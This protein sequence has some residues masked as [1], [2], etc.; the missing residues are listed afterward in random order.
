MV[1]INISNK[2]FYSLI[3]V[4]AITIVGVAVYAYGTS[5]PS[6]FGHSGE[7][8]NVNI[9]GQTKTLNQALAD[10]GAGGGG[11]GISSCILAGET[12]MSNPTGVKYFAVNVPAKCKGASC[13]LIAEV[14]SDSKFYGGEISVYSQDSTTN[15]IFVSRYPAKAYTNGDSIYSIIMTPISGWVVYDD[16]LSGTYSEK[17]ADQWTILDS[18]S[19]IKL[20]LYVC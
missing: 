1:N 11:G 20:K 6:V 19:T 9:N 2:V 14:V 17:S 7:E 3:A 12:P 5:N 18:S 15:H 13:S 10:L 16:M 4:I 8:I